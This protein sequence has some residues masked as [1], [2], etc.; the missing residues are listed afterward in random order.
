VARNWIGT[1]GIEEAMYIMAEVDAAGEE[2]DG[3]RCYVL[4]FPG[5]R[6]LEVDSFWSVTLYRRADC[7]LAANPM[8]RHSI[9]DRTQG[10]HRDPDGGLSIAI[11]AQAPADESN[12]LPAPE[13]PF[14]LVLRLYQPR[15]AHT[16]S[17]FAYP[18]V[19]RVDNVS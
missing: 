7:L 19:V 14:Y 5:D 1:R 10:L 15:R 2:L 11:Q 3:Q 17:T 12:W 18:P 13:E 9:G 8:G 4:R 16:E 6:P